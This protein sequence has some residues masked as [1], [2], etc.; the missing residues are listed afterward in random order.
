MQVSLGSHTIL[1]VAGHVSEALLEHYVLA[2]EELPERQRREIPH[3]LAWCSICRAVHDDLESFYGALAAGQRA[4][5]GAS[6]D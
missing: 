2:P 6:S 3:H 4:L 1:A 5:P